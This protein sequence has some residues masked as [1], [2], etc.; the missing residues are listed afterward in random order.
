MNLVSLLNFNKL[1]PIL[2]FLIFLVFVGKFPAQLN[3]QINSLLSDKKFRFNGVVLI[4]RDG[5]QIYC[6]VKGY[7]HF[8]DKTPLKKDQQFVIGSLSKQF[9]AVM[10]LQEYEKGHIDLFAPISLYLPELKPSWADTVTVHQL[11]THTH[12]IVDLT[13]STEFKPGT[14]FSYSQLGYELLSQ[15]IERISGKS[16]AAYSSE[17]FK[18]CGMGKT[19]HPEFLSYPGFTKGYTLDSNS[20]LQVEYNSFRNYAA[21]G[22]F[23]STAEDLLI[24]NNALFA[25]KLLKPATLELMVTQKKMAIRNH[26]LFGTTYYGYGITR[27]E[28][29]DITSFGLTGFTP[30]FVSLNFFFP[31]SKTSVIIL[32]N[33]VYSDYMALNFFYH[34]NILMLVEEDLKK[35]TKN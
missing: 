18:S 11:L 27:E 26:P 20:V 1:K 8:T 19:L 16:F 13:N 5:K 4:S 34:L 23:I 31:E 7:S 17:L 22:T 35:Q 14:K 25:N 24:W 33:I 29:G 28:K 9:T 12:G 10:I 15:I 2:N 21:A 6:K 30:G 3:R 32:Q